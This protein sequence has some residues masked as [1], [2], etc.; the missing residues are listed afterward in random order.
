MKGNRSEGNRRAGTGGGKRRK[1]KGERG[2][3]VYVD[4]LACLKS[5]HIGARTKLEIRCL[6]LWRHLLNSSDRLFSRTFLSAVAI[7]SFSVTQR[8]QRFVLFEYA[9]ARIWISQLTWWSMPS[10]LSDQ[11]YFDK[12]VWLALSACLKLALWLLKRCLKVV[13]VEPM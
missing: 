5:D 13:S 9:G 12:A 11:M 10:F 4:A 7:S 3:N 2:K 1:K 6:F 8:S